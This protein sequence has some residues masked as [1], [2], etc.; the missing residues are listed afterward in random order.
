MKRGIVITLVVFGLLFVWTSVDVQAFRIITKQ[1]LE[2]ETVTKTD[3]IR[4]VD[5]FIVLFDTSSSTNQMVPGRNVS[6]IA[7]AKA[8]LKE[9][10]SWLPELGYNAGLYI[11]TNFETLTGTFEEVYGM[12]PYDRAAFGTAID[13]LPDKGQGPTM[14]QVGLH[15]LRKLVAGLSGKTAVIM[16]TDGT[17]TINRGIK[18]PLQI[19]QEITKDHDVCFYL[20]SSAEANAE[21]QLLKGVTAVNPCSRVIPIGTFLDNPNY[22]GGALYTTKATSY[23]RLKPVTR[24]VGVEIENILFD[25]NSADLRGEYEEKLNMLGDYLK[26]NPDAYV[27]TSGYADSVGDEDYNM[28]LSKRRAA[29]AKAFLVDQVGIDADRIVDRW[30]GELNPTAD[31]GTAQGRQLNRRVEIAV[32][33]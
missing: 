19:A 28:A 5:N 27:V 31:N 26:N 24:V 33:K 7:A 32:G 4:N 12:K 11:Y 6:K 2:E 21:K 18:R 3:L 22:V 8:M 20:I 10:N 1:M 25:F 23:Q 14:L 17:F 13:Q 9:R 29:S 16:F 30:F 15:G